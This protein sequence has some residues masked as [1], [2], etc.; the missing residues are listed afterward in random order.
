MLFRSKEE[1]HTTQVVGEEGEQVPQLE[2]EVGEKEEHH[3]TQVVGE[4]GEEE[5]QPSEIE[6]EEGEQFLQ[7][8]GEDGEEEEHHPTQVEGEEGE[9]RPWVGREERQGK[10]RQTLQ[11][12]KGEDLQNRKKD[13]AVREGLAEG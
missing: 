7:I 6:G 1:H 2:G 5:C 11:V 8:E 4:E 9:Q 13:S 3:T 12:D 10:K